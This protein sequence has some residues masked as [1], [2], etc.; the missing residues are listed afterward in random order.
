MLAS[1]V[2]PLGAFFSPIAKL[3]G[4][5]RNHAY[6]TLFVKLKL[7][8]TLMLVAA[9]NR[10]LVKLF[11]HMQPLDIVEEFIFVLCCFHVDKGGGFMVRKLGERGGELSTFHPRKK[12]HQQ[13]VNISF[14]LFLPFSLFCVK[15][16]CFHFFYFLSF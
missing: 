6:F 13:F 4:H 11:E 1:I 14:H 2:L 10:P 16:K 12:C 15:G 8:P 9:H 3:P 7:P 5:G